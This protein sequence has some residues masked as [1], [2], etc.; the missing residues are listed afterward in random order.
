MTQKYSLIGPDVFMDERGKMHKKASE[1][2]IPIKDK[3]TDAE[4][5]Y[6]E[7]HLQKKGRD[8]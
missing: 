6:V 1:G 8:K 7:K 4:D 2:F 5:R 3:Y